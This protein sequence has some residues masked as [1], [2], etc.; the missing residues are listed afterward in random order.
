L[1]PVSER[2]GKWINISQLLIYPRTVTNGTLHLYPFMTKKISTFTC[3]TLIR[4]LAFNAASGDAAESIFSSEES[5]EGKNAAIQKDLSKPEV[6]PV[7]ED[8]DLICTEADN[9]RNNTG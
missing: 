5:D 4:I 2:R 8:E 6:D 9:E 1:A 7:V 3:T